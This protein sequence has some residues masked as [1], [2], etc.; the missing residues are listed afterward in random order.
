MFLRRTPCSLF[1]YTALNRMACVGGGGLKVKSFMHVMIHINRLY[2]ASLASTQLPNLLRY[3]GYD[4][5]PV[6]S[7][8][9]NPGGQRHD[10]TRVALNSVINSCTFC[11]RASFASRTP[12]KE[13]LK[14]R[15]RPQ[16][17]KKS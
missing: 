2:K 9:L 7:G 15:A 5:Y 8:Y 6:C 16:L 1:G 11:G 10:N 12:W 3:R 14:G 4:Y 13:Y 17:V